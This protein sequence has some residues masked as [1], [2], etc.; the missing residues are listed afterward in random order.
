MLLVIDGPCGVS[1][2]LPGRLLPTPADARSVARF[3]RD[4]QGLAKDIIGTYISE[5]PT[6]KYEVGELA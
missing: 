5:P 2:C 1:R 6:K 4:C 3:L